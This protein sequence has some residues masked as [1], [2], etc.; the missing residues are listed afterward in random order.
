MSKVGDEL[1][2]GLIE[3]IVQVVGWGFC[4]A[5]A[6]GFYAI[7]YWL[8]PYF[9]GVAHRD[10]FGVLSAIVMIWIYEHRQAHERWEKLK[11]RLDYLAEQGANRR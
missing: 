1:T 3:L 9:G 5:M 2:G 10:S 6:S 7:G 11:D 4:M 8:A